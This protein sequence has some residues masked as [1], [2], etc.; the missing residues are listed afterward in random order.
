MP[1]FAPRTALDD[2]RDATY[3]LRGR[4]YKEFDE[5]YVFTGT[6]RSRTDKHNDYLLFYNLTLDQSAVR[7]LNDLKHMSP[8]CNRRKLTKREIK[9]LA[10]VK[11]HLDLPGN[12]E[13]M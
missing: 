8:V 1:E 4:V 11:E 6:G 9:V 2:F 12:L 5:C 13:N 10:R 3:S 7:V